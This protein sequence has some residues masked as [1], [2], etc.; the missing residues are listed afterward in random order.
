MRVA[1]LLCPSA[2]AVQRLL[3]PNQQITNEKKF[4]FARER[5]MPALR[6]GTTNDE[7]ASWLRT[8]NQSEGGFWKLLIL[9][10]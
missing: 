5:P 1:T 7:K 6:A 2:E 4:A 8:S 9:Q 3:F 10:Q